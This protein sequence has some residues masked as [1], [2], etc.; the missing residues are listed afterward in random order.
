MNQC[1]AKC[2]MCFPLLNNEDR[3]FIC[4]LCL[5]ITIIFFTILTVTTID[6][7]ILVA[8][9]CI[10]F[11]VQNISIMIYTRKQLRCSTEEFL[12]ENEK[13]FQQIRKLHT[14][15]CK[16]SDEYWIMEKKLMSEGHYWKSRC[17]NIQIGRRQSFSS[18]ISPTHSP[19]IHSMESH[20]TQPQ[21]ERCQFSRSEEFTTSIKPK[22]SEEFSTSIKPKTSE[23]KLEMEQDIKKRS[24][25]SRSHTSFP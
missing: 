3:T 23:H 5:F 8:Y 10:F 25:L 22:S 18:A 15:R 12:Q 19:N 11:V 6:T 2:V 1:K 9:M 4:S 16:M 24:T 17:I 20:S 14:Q 13:Q 7:F 21:I